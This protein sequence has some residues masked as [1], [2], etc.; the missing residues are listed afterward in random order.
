MS[1]TTELRGSFGWLCN[2]TKPLNEYALRG[3]LRRASEEMEVASAILTTQGIV[4]GPDL[5]A[6]RFDSHG[7]RVWTDALRKSG[8]FRIPA[9]DSNDLIAHLLE[10]PTPPKLDLP[11]ELQFERVRFPP[12]PHLIV[13]KPNCLRIP[14]KAR[15]RSPLRLPGNDG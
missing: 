9:A 1:G 10:L 2:L 7:A 12:T 15:G 11:E 8:E 5:R 6:A 14:V 3:V 4:I 13:R